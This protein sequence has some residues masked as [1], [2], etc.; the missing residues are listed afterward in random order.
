MPEPTVLDV[1]DLTVGFGK[2]IVLLHLTF[3][4]PPGASLAI[5]G[6]NGSGKT[7]LLRSL[8]G[9]LPSTGAI[10]WAPDVRLGYVPQKL[11]LQRD[12]PISG[13]DFLLARSALARTER[14]RL[15][16]VSALVGLTPQMLRQ[17]IGALSGGQFQRLLIAFALIGRPTVLLL[18]EPTAGVDEPGQERLNELVHR[19]KREQG[20]TVILVS[21]EL[22]VVNRYAT[23]VLCLRQGAGWM[24][25]PRELL[26]PERLREVYG[27]PVAHHVH[28]H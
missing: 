23:L 7:V 6:P 19:L 17:P 2:H 28:D 8:I 15:E 24:G 5:I 22:N 3:S 13:R 12:V 18:D 11:D 1:D 20:L 9:A 16:E 25:P 14:S 21:H 10:R 26:T 27:E 4:V